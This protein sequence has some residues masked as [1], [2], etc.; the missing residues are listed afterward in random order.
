MI[1]KDNILRYDFKEISMNNIKVSILVPICNVEKY[2]TKCL[3]SIVNQTLKD[4]EIIC[5]NDGS[6]DNSLKII[7]EFADMDSRIVVIDKPNSGYGDSMNKGLDIAKGEY[8]GI[9]ESDDFADLNMFEDL[10]SLAKEYDAE[11]VKSNY[12]MYWSNPEK[13]IEKNQLN[14]TSNII[15]LKN[16]DD[17]VRSITLI[18]TAIYKRKWLDENKIRFLP[19]PG[20]SYQDTSFFYKTVLL[21]NKIILTPKSY[22]FY[23]QDNVNSS[24]KAVNVN[25]RLLAHREFEEVK[26]FIKENNFD[27]YLPIICNIMLNAYINNYNVIKKEDRKKYFYE[28]V[29]QIKSFGK[30]WCPYYSRMSKVMKLGGYYSL[31]NNNIFLFSIFAS[32]SRIKKAILG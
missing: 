6:T 8:I 3:D 9:V 1:K 29:G 25:K 16:K 15:N 7:N 2:L 27:D 21:A 19:T 26:K 12:K 30:D 24:F 20:A 10:Y 31:M 23:R 11:L 17:L 13:I 32:I 28:V 22:I 18:W 4:I 5:I 14:L